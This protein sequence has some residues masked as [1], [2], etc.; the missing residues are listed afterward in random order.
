MQ[1]VSVV[2]KSAGGTGTS[3]TPVPL[4]SGS[5]AAGT[6]CIVDLTGEGTDSATIIRDAFNLLNGWLW[7]PVPEEKLYVPPSGILGLKLPVAPASATS[8]VAGIIFEET[9]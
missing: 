3:F 6:A 8:F 2:R 9:G 1:Q 7:L 4:A 5:P